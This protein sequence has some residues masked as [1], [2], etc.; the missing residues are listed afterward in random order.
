MKKEKIMKKAIAG[1]CVIS[2]MQ[3]GC[4]N[5]RIRQLTPWDWTENEQLYTY[6][7]TNKK[8]DDTLLNQRKIMINS[9]LCPELSGEVISKLFYL[10][11]KDNKPIDIYLETMGGWYDDAWAISDAFKMIKSPVNI[12]VVGCCNSAG[13]I[14]LLGATGKR[15]ITQNS[16]IQIHGNLKDNENKNTYDYIDKNYRVGKLLKEKASL[17]EE[18]YPLSG[19]KYFTFPAE[20]ALKYKM[21]DEIIAGSK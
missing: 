12:C 21:V 13:V 10:D 5:G 2:I 17:P 16:V 15:Y 9:Y 6:H 18:W 19:E 7:S 14:V 20:D 8:I 1:I 4:Y 3:I 11:A